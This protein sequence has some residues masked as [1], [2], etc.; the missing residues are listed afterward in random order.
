MAEDEAAMQAGP[1]E[2]REKD[3]ARRRS[4]AREKAPEEEVERGRAPARAIAHPGIAIH[5]TES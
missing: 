3:R 2:E 5:F 1:A 4:R